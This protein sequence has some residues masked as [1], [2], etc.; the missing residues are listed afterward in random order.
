LAVNIR[1]LP[2]ILPV[3]YLL[4]DEKIL[5][6]SVSGSK[7]DAAIADLVVAFQVDDY[8]DDGS[9]G[10]SV[11]IQGVPSEITDPAELSRIEKLPLQTWVRVEGQVHRYLAIDTN[12]ISGRQFSAN[13]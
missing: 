2:V 1:A 7:L 13:G 3:N 8:A 10:W 6:R 11:L 4:T 12:V 9:W 5:I